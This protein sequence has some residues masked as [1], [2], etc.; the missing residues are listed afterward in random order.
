MPYEDPSYWFAHFLGSYAHRKLCNLHEYALMCFMM[1]SRMEL[2]EWGQI[3][4]YSIQ[5]PLI[6]VR[7]R[8]ILCCCQFGMKTVNSEGHL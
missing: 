5:V 3:C 4:G 6:L 2:A 7:R 1:P 8:H